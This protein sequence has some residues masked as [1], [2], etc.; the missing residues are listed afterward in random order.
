MKLRLADDSLKL[1]RVLG[2][3]IDAF[4]GV[5]RI[6]E[7]GVATDTFLNPEQR[8]SLKGDGPVLMTPEPDPAGTRAAEIAISMQSR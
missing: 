7:T 5:V 1:R 2:A 4:A 6:T 8:Y 3:S